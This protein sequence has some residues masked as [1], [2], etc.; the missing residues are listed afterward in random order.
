MECAQ[1]SAQVSGID[2]QVPNELARSGTLTMR[3]FV[4]HA[5]F[6][7]S[8]GTLRKP[9]IQDT[10]LPRIKPV[11]AADIFDVTIDTHGPYVLPRLLTL[12]SIRYVTVNVAQA[13]E[14]KKLLGT[15]QTSSERRQ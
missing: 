13:S 10:D 3:D 2:T 12:S 15:R 6:G 4:Q 11:E 9:T 7:Q 8:E 14:P 5:Y 1:Y